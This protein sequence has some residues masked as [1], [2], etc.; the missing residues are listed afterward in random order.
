[1]C[2]SRAN[3]D[4]LSGETLRAG[5]LGPAIDYFLHRD[6][7]NHVVIETAECQVVAVQ[8]EMHGGVLSSQVVINADLARLGAA[9]P[10]VGDEHLD[11]ILFEAG[12]F[13]TTSVRNRG[14]S[15]HIFRC[16]FE[17]VAYVVVKGF[18]ARWN[19][20]AKPVCTCHVYGVQQRC[21][22]TLFVEGLGL[23][24]R[25]RDFSELAAQRRPG[26]PKG[27]AKAE[28][29]QRHASQNASAVEA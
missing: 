11:T 24:P 5:S 16:L 14:V 1:M 18:P 22:Q 17:D 20:L 8:N 19:S 4:L 2:D 7:P 15:I 3:P 26:R 28:A 13:F 10:F 6:T 27:K 12:I 21:Q 23:A 25:Q 29:R 9:A